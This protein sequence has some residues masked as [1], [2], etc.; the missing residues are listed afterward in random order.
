MWGR[1]KGSLVHPATFLF[2]KKYPIFSCAENF[3]K[4]RCQLTRNEVLASLKL[5]FLLI[6]ISLCLKSSDMQI[7]TNKG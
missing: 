7:L 6:N 1:Q 5:H 3:S 4:G 2:S